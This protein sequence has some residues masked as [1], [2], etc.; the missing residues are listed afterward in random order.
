MPHSEVP[1]KIRIRLQRAAAPRRA[2]GVMGVYRGRQVSRESRSRAGVKRSGSLRLARAA[3][4]YRACCSQHRP[5]AR[6]KSITRNSCLQQYMPPPSYKAKYCAPE[7]MRARAADAD[8]GR[9]LGP[10]TREPPSDVCLSRGAPFGRR[11]MCAPARTPD[12][13]GAKDGIVQF[14]GG[15]GG[16]WE[17]A[18]LESAGARS[19]LGLLEESSIRWQLFF[20][21]LARLLLLYEVGHVSFL[22]MVLVLKAGLEKPVQCRVEHVYK[23]WMSI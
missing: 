22:C 2:S 14:A 5:A 20:F 17:A 8:D 18:R 16:L 4:H 1:G 21:F 9:V 7:E 13:R 15:K 11:R 12:A 23:L 19:F 6:A 3:F 10:L